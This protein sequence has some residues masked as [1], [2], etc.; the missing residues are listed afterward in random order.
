MNS[1]NDENDEIDTEWIREFEKID[2]NYKDLY[3]EDLSFIVLICIYINNENE[4]I[5]IKKEKI[6]MSEKI[7]RKEYLSQLLKKYGKTYNIS[8]ILKYNINLQPENIKYYISSKEDDFIE[9]IKN[10]DDIY[11]N[12]SIKMFE[13][14]NNLIMIFYENK[15]IKYKKNTKKILFIKNNKTLKKI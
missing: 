8:S 1:I 13:D 4:I 10:I 14:L 2:N 12:K 3:L 9:I 5:K 6:M 11:W 7:I 15:E